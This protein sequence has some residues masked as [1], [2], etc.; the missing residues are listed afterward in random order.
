MR[1]LLSGSVDTFVNHLTLL[2]VESGRSRPSLATRSS[3]S[4]SRNPTPKAMPVPD[5]MRDHQ[6]TFGVT[7][8]DGRYAANRFREA[9]RRRKNSLDS[10]GVCGCRT[11]LDSFWFLAL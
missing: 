3:S 8:K 1:E 5:A 9:G 11:N 6:K 2:G 4:S 7:P 10:R